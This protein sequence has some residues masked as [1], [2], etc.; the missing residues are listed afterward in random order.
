[1]IL[2]ALSQSF[3][4]SNQYERIV[5]LVPS[6]TE[7]LYHLGVQ[8]KLVGVTRYCVHPQEARSNQV[9][10]G[11]TKQLMW[12]KFDSLKADLVIGNKEENT[13]EIFEFLSDKKVP[14]YVAFPQSIDEAIQDISNLGQLFNSSVTDSI[15]SSIKDNR[16]AS[17]CPNKHFSFAYLI[18]RNPW[19]TINSHTF[20]AQML[21]E[22]G[23]INVYQ[24]HKTRYPT[25]T[26]DDLKEKSPDVV[27]LSSE[28]YPFGPEHLLEIQTSG[29]RSSIIEING[30]YS[31]WH[32]VRMRDAFPYLREIRERIG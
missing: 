4:P 20:I 21:R 1:M 30:E 10:I 31:S 28:P 2:D 14:Y 8:E 3:S 22:V 23:G 15:I 29:V 5:S 16:A 18:W 6:T 13:K 19:M 12:E 17:S 25:I 32:G 27:F 11:G 7:T 9:V 24:D 26:L